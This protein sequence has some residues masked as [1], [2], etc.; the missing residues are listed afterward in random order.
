METVGVGFP[1]VGAPH[2][3]ERAAV[4][5]AIK[6]YRDNRRAQHE[7]VN[8]HGGIREAGPVLVHVYSTHYLVD[9]DDLQHW[10]RLTPLP[11]QLPP[12]MLGMARRDVDALMERWN[13][14]TRQMP[15]GGFTMSE[16][17]LWDVLNRMVGAQIM[18]LRAIEEVAA[19]Q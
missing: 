12:S 13:E 19:A 6:P 18:L 4:E 7:W 1:G 14:I 8:Q 11:G 15:K 16:A 5:A 17:E 9:G 3:A 2:E 10:M